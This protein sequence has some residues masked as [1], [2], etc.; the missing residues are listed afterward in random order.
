MMQ[1][2]QYFQ[3]FLFTNRRTLE[4]VTDKNKSSASI[5]NYMLARLQKMFKYSGLPESIPRQYLENYLLVNGSCIIARDKKNPS[6]ES[7]Y[8][9]VGSAG[10]EPDIYYRPTKY[11]VANPSLNFSAEYY[12]SDTDPN[13]EPDAILIRNDTMWQGLYPMMARYAALI[14]ENLLTLRT[15][16]IMLRVLALITA[17]DDKSREAA[18]IFLKNIV[19]GKL[20]SISENRFLDGIRM[21]NPPSNNGSY[22]TQ[23]IELHQYLVGSFYNEVGLNANY[24]MKREALSESETGLNDDSLMPLC[25]DMLRCRREDMQKVNALFGTS[26]EVDFDSSWLENTIERLLSLRQ[27][28]SEA[29]SQLDNPAPMEVGMES[30]GLEDAGMEGVSNQDASGNEEPGSMEAAGEDKGSMEEES[31]EESGG[32]EDGTEEDDNGSNDE[33]NSE[34]RPSEE[35]GSN[36]SDEHDEDSEGDEGDESEQ[37]DSE[38]ESNNENGEVDVNESIDESIEAHGVEVNVEVNFMNPPEDGAGDSTDDSTE[39]GADD[40]TNDSTE[41]GKEEDDGKEDGET[42]D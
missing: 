11:M 38:E 4:Y 12:I 27:Q 3:S 16:D 7:I 13:H 10:G 2:F 21:Q 15:A 14:S 8:A 1:D 19:D 18:D 34:E 36:D 17:P 28:A 30:V 42:E 22:L 35:E 31:T 23:F 37:G 33:S 29:S 39:D 26:I 25:E 9:F 40:N 24:N 6:D 5:I 41:D 32:E 20:G